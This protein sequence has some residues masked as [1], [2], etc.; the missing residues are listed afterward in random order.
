MITPRPF[1]YAISWAF[2]DRRALFGAA[3]RIAAVVRWPPEGRW[4]SVLSS[5]GAGAVLSASALVSA[6]TLP[7]PG[8]NGTGLRES[9][10]ASGLW[11]IE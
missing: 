9:G 2:T 3:A 8:A 7:S 5:A 4:N 6:R 11:Q 1:I 10:A